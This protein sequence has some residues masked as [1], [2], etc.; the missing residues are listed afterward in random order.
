MSSERFDDKRAEALRLARMVRSAIS[1]RGLL[2]LAGWSAL[3]GVLAAGC[4][5]KPESEMGFAPVND[6]KGQPAH[7][8][9]GYPRVSVEEGEAA[10]EQFMAGSNIKLFP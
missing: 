7:F 6:E 4:S 9:E 3:S 2:E 10:V 1:R 8:K 5:L